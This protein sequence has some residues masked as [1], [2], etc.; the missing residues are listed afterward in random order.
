MLITMAIG[1]ILL[2]VAVPSMTRFLADQAAGGNAD[3]FVEALRFAR[4]EAIKRGQQVTLC[5][6]TNLAD[7]ATEWKDGWIVMAAGSGR[8][9]R[10]QNALRAINSIDSPATTLTFEATG[11]VT[12]GTGVYQFVPIGGDVDR[13]RRV[14]ITVQGRVSVAKGGC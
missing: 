2:A 13:C 11:I 3:E 8:I 7:C 14:N 10:A 5:A 1:G 6:S 4:T 9:L 12:A